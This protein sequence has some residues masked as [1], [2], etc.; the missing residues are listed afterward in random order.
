MLRQVRKHIVA[1]R[2]SRESGTISLMAIN[3][4]GVSFP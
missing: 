1:G 2:K 4:L 3:S